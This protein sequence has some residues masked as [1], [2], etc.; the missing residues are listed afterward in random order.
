LAN[1]GSIWHRHKTVALVVKSYRLNSHSK[2]DD[3][4]PKHILSVLPDPLRIFSSEL[5]VDYSRLMD[6]TQN[7]VSS[8]WNAALKQ[9]NGDFLSND[10]KHQIKEEAQVI[11]GDKKRINQLINHSIER[12]LKD[13]GLFI[14][15]DIVTQWHQDDLPY[16]GAF[17]VSL[18]LS[19]KYDNVVGTSISES[20]LVG[21]AAGRA[22]ASKKTSVVEIMF[23]DFSTL[24]IDQLHN[25]VD[26]YKKMF[27]RN[28]SIPLV[29]RLP[30]GMGRGYG[31]THS[32]SPFELFSGLTEVTVVSYTPFINYDALIRNISLSGSSAVVFEPKTIYGDTQKS[33]WEL[34]DGLNHEFDPG[35]LVHDLLVKK[36]SNPKFTLL[37]HGS[38]TMAS[39]EAVRE[40]EL[41]SQVLIVGELYRASQ[42]LDVLNIVDIPT[43]I[44]EETNCNIGPLWS[45]T[46][47]EI[48]RS[49]NQTIVASESVENIPANS[50]WER[51]LVIDKDTVLE[52]IKEALL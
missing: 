15:E 37:T 10:N 16:G 8:I 2:G 26:K 25:G 43:I 39:L 17:G 22:F 41:D 21:V 9:K 5:G 35:E 38:T 1:L 29:V 40:L 44:V 33:W 4:R 12:V 18:G 46:S 11:E 7:K 42:Y 34:L 28:V 6:E 45:S 32:Q 36:G 14:G 52:L 19:D 48:S 47:R 24:I 49:V 3:T 13:D 23:A 51:N 30:Y 50:Q 31:P 27:G 20:G